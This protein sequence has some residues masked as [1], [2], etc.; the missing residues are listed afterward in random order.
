MGCRWNV[1]SPMRSA[2]LDIVI[3]V[4]V[5]LRSP[6]SHIPGFCPLRTP[7]TPVNV[8]VVAAVV[9]VTLS[10]LCLLP[11]AAGGTQPLCQLARH[12]CLRGGGML[13][14]LLDVIVI[15][16][17][18]PQS[19]PS[20][21]PGIHQM[22]TPDTPVDVFII[23]AVVD[24]A[25]SPLCPPSVMGQVV[26]VFVPVVVVIIILPPCGGGTIIPPPPSAAVH[27]PPF[28]SLPA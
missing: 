25:L 8:L 22:R 10:L 16:A 6:P 23:N 14:A 17:V 4:T 11:V 9:D 7:D 3:I 20:P 5:V 27:L 13:S 2:L 12:R 19:P 28:P 1:A 15:V 21:I 26:I 18:T 24:I